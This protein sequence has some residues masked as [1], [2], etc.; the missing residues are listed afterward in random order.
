MAGVPFILKTNRFKIGNFGGN[1][2]HMEGIHGGIQIFDDRRLI[3]PN[4]AMLKPRAF[5]P[6]TKRLDPLSYDEYLQLYNS[7][8]SRGGNLLY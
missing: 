3:R 7:V 1:A 4:Y 6:G 8:D 2:L 5:I